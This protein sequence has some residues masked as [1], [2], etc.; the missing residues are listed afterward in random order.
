MW[1]D[2]RYHIHNRLAPPMI[3]RFHSLNNSLW[4][5]FGLEVVL[6]RSRESLCT[7]I[8]FAI[9]MTRRCSFVAPSWPE[10]RS[11]ARMQTNQMATLTW[12]SVDW[13]SKCLQTNLRGGNL[14][15]IVQ[16][17]KCWRSCKIMTMQPRSRQNGLSRTKAH[18]NKLDDII[19]WKDWC[20]TYQSRIALP[21]KHRFQTKP[22][23]E[24]ETRTTRSST[25]SIVIVI[26]LSLLKPLATEW[27]LNQLEQEEPHLEERLACLSN[28]L[29]RFLVHILLTDMGTP[30]GN[31]VFIKY[32]GLIKCHKKFWDSGDEFNV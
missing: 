15:A 27:V 5:S 14:V 22:E 2:W 32:V 31:S 1:S 18:L 25:F 13:S 19:I 12:W 30:L 20:E 17:S 6:S 21:K 8:V 24:Q 11:I 26:G 23:I 3:E 4:T 16:H 29:T 28:L 7:S 9:T 10:P